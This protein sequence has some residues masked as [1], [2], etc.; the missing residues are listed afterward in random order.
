[1][2]LSI[3]PL[4]AP[5][6]IH[7]FGS[8]KT[9]SGESTG[10]GMLSK[11]RPEMTSAASPHSLRRRISSRCFLAVSTTEAMRTQVSAPRSEPRKTNSSLGQARASA[12]IPTLP[13]SVVGSVKAACPRNTVTLAKKLFI[14]RGRKDQKIKLPS[15]SAVTMSGASE[16]YLQHVT[17]ALSWLTWEVSE[18]PT[19]F[20]KSMLYQKTSPSSETPVIISCVSCAICKMGEPASLKSIFLSTTDRFGSLSSWMKIFFSAAQSVSTLE[21]VHMIC[22]TSSACG[23]KSFTKAPQA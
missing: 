23:T 10:L 22:E 5:S 17:A 19:C 8:E 2:M 3:C 6:T 12:V 4:C 13:A 11:M 15:L 7:S 20:A 21:G 9:Y 14:L 16:K 1:M 18:P